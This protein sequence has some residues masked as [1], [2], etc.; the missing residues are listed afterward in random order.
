MYP[1]VAPLLPAV[2]LVMSP[3]IPD[4]NTE[5]QAKDIFQFKAVENLPS[6]N[7]SD[8]KLAV[9]PEDIPAE[10]ERYGEIICGTAGIDA[11]LYY[12]DTAKEL[13]AGVG[14]YIGHTGAYIPGAGRTI[15]LAGHTNTVF[16]RL[17]ELEIGDKIQINTSYGQYEYEV[18][19][20]RVTTDTDSTAYDFTRIDENL[21][22]YTC[23]PFNYLGLTNQRYFVYAEYIS[24]PQ[25]DL[26][27]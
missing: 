7:L 2:S 22:L 14:T 23:Y 1:I 8:K 11:P 27:Y 18:N 12:G 9:S 16:R 13:K 26:V 3:E 24:G 10:G 5:L 15:L 17:G 21:I 19:D 25:L 4:F 20:S 6:D